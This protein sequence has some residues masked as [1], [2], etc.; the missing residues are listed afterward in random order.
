MSDA[1]WRGNDP[2]FQEQAVGNYPAKS[3]AADK[4]N[5]Y[6]SD[7][8]WVYRH[9]KSLDKS[10][11]WDEV[12]WAG[13]VT[14]PPAENEPIDAFPHS[15]V[16]YPSRGG[17]SYLP[18][19]LGTAEP[20][21]LVGDGIQFVSGPYPSASTTIGAIT[22]NAAESGD[23]A[24][25]IPFKAVLEDA[26]GAIAVGNTWAWSVSGPGTATF[27]AGTATG[28]FTATATTESNVS[29]T[30]PDEGDYTVSLT[31]GAA[32]G[33]STATHH[34]KAVVN[35]VAD[36]I[37]AYTISGT[38]TPQAGIG[39][40][41]KAN[42]G[43]DTTAPEADCTYTWSASPSSG[44]TI[45]QPGDD[46]LEAKFVFT[47]QGSVT[48]TT[49]TCVINDS[50][51]SDDGKTITYAVVP[52]FVIGAATITGP[53]TMTVDS[54][55]S[56]F[57]ISS[58]TGQSNPAPN[59]LTYKWSATLGGGATGSFNDDTAAAPTFTATAA[60]SVQVSVVVSSAKSEPTSAPK[61]NVISAVA[62]D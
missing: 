11:Y 6:L 29:I 58:Y 34:F 52:H 12:I 54:A 24:T 43:A 17:G 60:G 45:T 26:T 55:S 51:A 53:T 20:N 25:A 41:Y 1:V 50:S 56:A 44:V 39:V 59:D 49:I 16:V 61:S 33:D 37:G 46:P 10:K 36:L 22:I 4:D 42:P 14:D 30:F 3:D 18:G 9:Y 62:S 31:L 7:E 5:I 32:D 40:V 27:S 28:T 38:Q 19:Q 35:V 23:K 2:G 8:G 57:S 15:S 48:A 13:S 47:T 21:F